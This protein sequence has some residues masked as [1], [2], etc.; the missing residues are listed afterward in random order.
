MEMLQ[1][2]MRKGLSSWQEREEKV[3]SEICSIDE[4]P[5]RTHLHSGLEAK[6]IALQLAVWE[7]RYRKP[8]R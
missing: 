4:P 6:M 1:Q 5:R 8:A 3:L 7:E 2:M